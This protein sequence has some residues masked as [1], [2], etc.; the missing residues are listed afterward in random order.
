MFFLFSGKSYAIFALL[1]GLTFFI[2]SD[3]QAKKGKDFRLRF[4][5]RLVLLLGFG[6]INSAFY[7]GDILTI[8]AI[9][10]FS[11][12]PAAKLN[13]KTVS[14]IALILML[15]PWEWCNFVYGLQHPD[16]KRLRN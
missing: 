3:N 15:Q 1:F 16:L 14:W 8:Y 5:W 10:G 13:T 6:L 2:Q 9:L 4:A 12:I 11:L 7:E